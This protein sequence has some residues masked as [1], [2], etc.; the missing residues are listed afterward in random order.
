MIKDI[1]ELEQMCSEAGMGAVEKITV[2]N[3]ELY[4][5]DGFSRGNDECPEPHYRA[6]WAIADGEDNILVMQP[7]YF[8]LRTR[9]RDKRVAHM[10][11]LAIE[12]METRRALH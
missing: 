2:Q 6:M 7:V 10:K 5:A 4:I 12:F 3:G 8:S 11:E 1:R 9:D